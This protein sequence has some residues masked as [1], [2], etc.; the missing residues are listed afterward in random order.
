MQQETP[1]AK[2]TRK[3]F[4]SVSRSGEWK[5]TLSNRAVASHVTQADSEKDAR[6]R[7]R[8]IYE[9]GGLGQAVLHR[10]DGSIRTEHTYGKD[11]ERFPG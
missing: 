9:E 11:P 5:V 10:A 4:H 1:M 8:R 2:L 6:D 3:V 7:A